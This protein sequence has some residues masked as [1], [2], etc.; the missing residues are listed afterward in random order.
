MKT[1]MQ[2]DCE[3]L[4][5]NANAVV[6]SIGACTYDME[7]I[8]E[9]IELFPSV[10]EQVALGREID[11]DTLMWWFDQPDAARNN[12]IKGERLPLVMV[13]DEFTEW[14]HSQ[15]TTAGGKEKLWFSAYGVDFDLPLVNTL[16]GARR[17]MPWEGRPNYKQKM[18]LRTLNEVYAEH[19]EW[20]EGKTAHTARADAINQAYAH[21]S[22]LKKFPHL[23]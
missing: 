9:S 23:R 17:T 19:I 20:P 2:V 10:S 8:K 14:A 7:G 15:R 6:L 16:L 13:A 3:T 12:I 22:L 21:I 11:D 1:F 5:L 18:C 4:A